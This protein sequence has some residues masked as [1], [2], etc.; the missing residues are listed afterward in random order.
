[1]HMIINVLLVQ[2]TIC[3]M[4]LHATQQISSR[5]GK[6][7]SVIRDSLRKTKRRKV[8]SCKRPL[9]DDTKYSS[10]KGREKTRVGE[11]LVPKS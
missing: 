8:L 4:K 9:H 5:K 10:H 2:K 6:L 3:V 1:M 11:D 7:H